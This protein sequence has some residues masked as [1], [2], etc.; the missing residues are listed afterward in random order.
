MAGRGLHTHKHTRTHTHTYTHTHTHTHTYNALKKMVF[1]SMLSRGGKIFFFL[2]NFS[3][4]R[5][6]LKEM[7]IIHNIDIVQRRISR[8][9]N[10]C[11]F[12]DSIIALNDVK[13]ISAKHL[14]NDTTTRMYVCM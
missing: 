4:Q 7:C 14:L 12:Y 6:W 13:S 11:H 9:L 8:D 5:K 2:H 3:L 10:R 1:F